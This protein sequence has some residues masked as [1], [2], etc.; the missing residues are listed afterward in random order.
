MQL[1]IN[2]TGGGK[3]VKY[4][5]SCSFSYNPTT[6]MVRQQLQNKFNFL[7]WSVKVIRELEELTEDERY[8]H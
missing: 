7:Y 5:H 3:N 2:V 1:H 8:T 4:E 6:A